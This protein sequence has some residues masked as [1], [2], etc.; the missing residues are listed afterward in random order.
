MFL[1]SRSSSLSKATNTPPSSHLLAL[2]PQNDSTK[3]HKRP[4]LL[5]C[6]PPRVHVYILSKPF[7]F[8]FFFSFVIFCLLLPRIRQKHIFFQPGDCIVAL[9]SV[10]MFPPCLLIHIFEKPFTI[11]FTRW[12][13]FTAAWTQIFF[14]TFFFYKSVCTVLQK[15]KEDAKDMKGRVFVAHVKVF[16]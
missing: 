12:A 5:R 15:K 11:Y 6:F 7:F 14:I 9:V 13:A 3:Q 4:F 10:L 16:K 2:R 8:S 1:P